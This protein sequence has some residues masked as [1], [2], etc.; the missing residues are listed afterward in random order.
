MCFVI[1]CLLFYICSGL[2]IN[3][4]CFV[5]MRRVMSKFVPGAVQHIYQRALDH[6]V[7]F[8]SEEDRLVYYTLAAVNSRKFGVVVSAAS[9]MFTHTHQG[10]QAESLI[11]LRKYLQNTNSSFTRQY[12]IYHKRKGEMFDWNPGR[13][14]KSSLKEKRS[15]IIYIYN[16]HVEKK[17]CAEAVQERWSFLAYAFS[18]NPFSDK[19]DIHTSSAALRKAVKLVDRRNKNHSSIKYK[20]LEYIFSDLSPNEYEQIVDYIIHKYAW[21]DFNAAISLFGNPQSMVVAI[22]SSTGGEH[23]IKEDY[24]P[25]SDRAY[26]E[27]INIAKQNNCLADIYALSPAQKGD[28]VIRTMRETNVRLHQINKFLHDNIKITR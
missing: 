11:R 1:F 16:N 22:N 24:S 25:S 18:D 6:G 23:S 8:Y 17:L 12:N 4:S 21:V 3:F 27:L 7:I 10:V 20:D 9:L 5:C 19:I 14:Q 28:F 13:A 26:L 15:A 2:G